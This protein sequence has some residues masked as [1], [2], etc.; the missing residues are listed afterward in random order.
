MVHVYI[1]LQL[2]GG[3]VRP[4]DGISCIVCMH[5]QNASLNL[6]SLEGTGIVKL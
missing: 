3:T 4:I 2:H 6:L 5:K 1:T